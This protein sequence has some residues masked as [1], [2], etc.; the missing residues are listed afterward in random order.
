M[1]AR[2]LLAAFCLSLA[3]TPSVA[4]ADVS[5]ADRATART[6]ALE[7]YEALQKN[8]YETAL[9]RFSR[10]DALV[11]A[12]TLLIGVA[13]AQV[14]LGKWIE[15]QETYNRIVR[16]GAAPGS[17]EPFFRA[18]EDARKELDALTLRTPAV[19]I[20]VEGPERA[21]VTIDGTPVPKVAL[22]VR[23]PVDP[24]P[25]VLRAM[26]TGYAPGEMTVTAQEGKVEQV[27]LE[28]QPFESP[29]PVAA[30]TAK[31]AAKP[32]TVGKPAQVSPKG[33]LLSGKKGN[34]AGWGTQKTLGVV[35]L[36]VGGM[37][38]VLGVVTGIMAMNKHGEL[39]DACPGDVCPRG[40]QSTLGSYRTLG[41]LSTV[42]FIVGAVGAAA[43]ATLLLT[44]PKAHKDGEVRISP[45][46]GLGYVG[47]DG[48]F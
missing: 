21:L 47:V 20:E 6:L 36:Q 10:A 46:A 14:G 32:E 33:A 13:R 17:P 1:N 31:T 16:E 5:D 8:D 24:G 44:A 2:R 25:H 43:G 22:G 12:P 26:S 7:G 4:L 42:G 37:G 40:R 18:L 35:A 11:H 9:D 48:V 3:L 41:A 23:M 28:L 39:V 27:I 19:V 29:K 30:P 38:V 45:I 15:A 34:P